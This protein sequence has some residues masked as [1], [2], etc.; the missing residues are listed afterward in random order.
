MPF[1]STFLRYEVAVI[2]PDGRLLLSD[3]RD[4]VHRRAG[5]VK[6]LG[7]QDWSGGRRK[8]ENA[9]VAFFRSRSVLFV[10]W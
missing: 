1:F 8:Q 7:H 2:H 10:R 9:A 4:H 6:V 3:P 5:A